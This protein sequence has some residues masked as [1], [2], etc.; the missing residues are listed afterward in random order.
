MD[1]LELGVLNDENSKLEEKLQ[2]E[3]D[4]DARKIN[5]ETNSSYKES[6]LKISNEYCSVDSPADLVTVSNPSRR[7]ANPYS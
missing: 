7:L 4:A 5:S 1:S 2:I 6:N 3:S